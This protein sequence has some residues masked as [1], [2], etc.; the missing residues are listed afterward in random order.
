MATMI[1]GHEPTIRAGVFSLTDLSSNYL[2][3]R[4]LVEGTPVLH[5]VT[6]PEGLRKEQIAEIYQD[7]L[8][9]DADVFL[10]LC[11]DPKFIKS[12]NIE[13]LCLEGFLFPETYHFYKGEIP[14]RIIQTMVTEYH[15]LFDEILENRLQIRDLT[16]LEMVTLAS[17]IEGEAIYDSERSLISSVYHNRLAK[18]MRLQ[19][20]PT[21]QLSLIHI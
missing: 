10:A 9:I 19:A 17:I 3:I 15:K 16:E 5:K 12:L 14:E 8:N 7:K 11:E 2:I 4:Q 18:E 21:I 13:A 1:M 20:D 6:I